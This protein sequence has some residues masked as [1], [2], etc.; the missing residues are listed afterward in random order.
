MALLMDCLLPALQTT[1]TSFGAE[2][3]GMRP[4]FPPKCRECKFCFCFFLPSCGL[5]QRERHGSRAAQLP[6]QQ[7]KCQ[8]NPNNDLRA[9]NIF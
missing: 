6:R 5:A 7:E 2:M 9:K 3:I 4:F 1:H 8:I